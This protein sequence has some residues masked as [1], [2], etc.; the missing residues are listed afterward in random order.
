MFF[1]LAATSLAVRPRILVIRANGTRRAFRDQLDEDELIV[2]FED[3]RS[4]GRTPLPIHGCIGRAGSSRFKYAAGLAILN[5]A[6]VPFRTL[7][8]IRRRERIAG[9]TALMNDLPV[10]AAFVRRAGLGVL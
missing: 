10:G 2:T 9:L 7:D 5:S 8:I 1:L 6:H 3:Q 4:V